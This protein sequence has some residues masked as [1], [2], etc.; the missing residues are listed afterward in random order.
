M[1]GLPPLESVPAV[2]GSQWADQVAHGGHCS[3]RVPQ[4]VRPELPTALSS[5]VYFYTAF[6][7][8]RKVLYCRMSPETFEMFKKVLSA[9]TQTSEVLE[10][11]KWSHDVA[12]GN[13]DLAVSQ[14][15]HLGDHTWLDEV[16]C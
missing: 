2:P 4:G 15:K 8:G 14:E 13:G 1:R 7:E 16:W 3:L 10:K 12:S 11:D 9:Q 6:P 5:P